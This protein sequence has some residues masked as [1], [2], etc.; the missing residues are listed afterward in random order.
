MLNGAYFV[1]SGTRAA[2][3]YA[4]AS[5]LGVKSA[6]LVETSTEGAEVLF[7]STECTLNV[8]S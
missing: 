8:K 7:I 5:S 6:F 2:D 3:N 4:L 1:I